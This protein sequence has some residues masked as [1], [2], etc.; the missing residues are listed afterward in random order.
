MNASRKIQ[1]G[2]G[3]GGIQRP[4]ERGVRGIGSNLFTRGEA[5]HAAASPIVNVPVAVLV[6][7]TPSRLTTVWAEDWGLGLL[8]DRT[9]PGS[10]LYRYPSARDTRGGVW[11]LDRRW[12]WLAIGTAWRLKRTARLCARSCFGTQHGI[13]NGGRAAKP[14]I[15][16]VHKLLVGELP[17]YYRGGCVRI[18]LHLNICSGG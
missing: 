8:L 1:S 5:T 6:I 17:R 12:K 14:I 16:D 3:R 4:A 15:D 7:P 18:H 11:Q 9:P 13:L 10:A 2:E